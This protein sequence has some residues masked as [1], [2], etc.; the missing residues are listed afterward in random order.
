MKP[1]DSFPLH[2][3]VNCQIN[4]RILKFDRLIYQ[5]LD[6]IRQYV[7]STGWKIYGTVS[8]ELSEKMMTF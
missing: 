3:G 1:E 8:K 4:S 6:N 2:N 7:W 5:D